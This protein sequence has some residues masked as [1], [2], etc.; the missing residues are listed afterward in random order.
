MRTTL[1]NEW[2]AFRL[3]VASCKDCGTQR[4]RLRKPNDAVLGNSADSRASRKNRRQRAAC[5]M[6][7]I[8]YGWPTTHE[9]IT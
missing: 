6:K 5:R 2:R 8:T 4:S 9:G 3:K 7:R 1:H